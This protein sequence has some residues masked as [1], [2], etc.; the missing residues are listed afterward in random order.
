MHSDG[1]Y[2]RTIKAFKRL[3]DISLVYEPAYEET[4][5][6]VA[7]RGLI[8]AQNDMKRIQEEQQRQIRA[9]YILYANIYNI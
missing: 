9:S 5:V 8:Q 6:D 2:R 4:S 1:L 3:Y 7:K